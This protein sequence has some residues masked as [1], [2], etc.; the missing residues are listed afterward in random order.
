MYNEFDKKLFPSSNFFCTTE[1]LYALLLTLQHCNYAF[2]N[3]TGNLKY[4]S[5]LWKIPSQANLLKCNY[6]MMSSVVC[7]WWIFQ[8]LNWIFG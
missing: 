2:Y 4:I 3:Y 8:I 7:R 5:F 1:K 6:F